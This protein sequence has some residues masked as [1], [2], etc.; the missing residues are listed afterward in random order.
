MNKLALGLALAALATSAMAN[1][2]STLGESIAAS[3]QKNDATLKTMVDHALSTPR[4]E[5]PSAQ[6]AK[7]YFDVDWQPAR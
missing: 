2:H 3:P 7:H 6:P 4:K 1:E 5:D